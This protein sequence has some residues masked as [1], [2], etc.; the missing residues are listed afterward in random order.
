MFILKTCESYLTT[1]HNRPTQVV[2]WLKHTNKNISNLS[3][4]ITLY[5]Y[6]T[7]QT[8]TYY[9]YE[10]SDVICTHYVFRLINIIDT[11]TNIFAWHQ[12]IVFIVT[13]SILFSYWYQ[14]KLRKTS[15]WSNLFTCQRHSILFFGSC[16]ITILYILF[17]IL[18]VPIWF[19]LFEGRRVDLTHHLIYACA[20]FIVGMIVHVNLYTLYQ[21][22]SLTMQTYPVLTITPEFFDHDQSPDQKLS[23]GG[24]EYHSPSH[25]IIIDDSSGIAS[26]RFLTPESSL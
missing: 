10:H 7:N 26:K 17:F 25:T 11:V 23:V 16:S 22:Y 15:F 4:N 8:I 21:W 20:K 5:Q 9:N 2:C 14:N 6:C 18:L 3:T 24:S 1:Y 19:Y 12:A 13:K